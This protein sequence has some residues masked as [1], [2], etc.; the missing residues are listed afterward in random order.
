MPRVSQAPQGVTDG[1]SP[2]G[3][4]GFTDGCEMK[5]SPVR[6][7]LLMLVV[8]LAA[9][10]TWALIGSAATVSR[11]PTAILKIDTRRSGNDF[12]VGAVGLATDALELSGGRLS[13]SDDSLVRLMR[14]LGPA[15]L[16]VGGGNVD[17]S[18]WTSSNEAPPAWATSTITPADLSTLHSLLAVTGWRVLL[19]VDLGHFEPARVADEA[20]YAR[21]IL[22]GELLGIEIGNEPDGYGEK[23]GNRKFSLRPASYGVDEYVREAATYRRELRAATPGLAVYGPAA[24]GS[25]WL[26]R[27]GVAGSMFAVL[28]Q[29]YY[30]TSTCPNAPAAEPPP[31]AAGILSPAVRLRED[32]ALEV[33]AQ[34]G[35]ITGRSIRIDET[36]DI[37]YCSEGTPGSPS[38]ASALWALDWTLRAVSSGVKGVNF[39]GAFGKCADNAQSQTPICSTGR[40]AA[41]AGDVA[42]QPEYYG[43]LAARQLEGGRFVPASLTAPSQLPNITTWATVASN[44]TVRIAIDNMAIT[45]LA[46]PVSI[47]ISGY[48]GTEETLAAP[49]AE[50]GSGITLG[51]VVV[52]STEKWRP[53]T[54]RLFHSRH[55]ARI[56]IQPASAVVVTLRPKRLPR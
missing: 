9:A 28:T 50:A 45:G 5:G 46:Q 26:I 10:G 48:T 22:G 41:D 33:I 36:N 47:P 29:H 11:A 42:P 32:Q 24:G 7:V 51:G 4:L 12:A 38:M 44:G 23:T 52:T 3:R 16:R 40:E 25:G 8:V 19:G 43:L 15:V 49:S 55:L 2:T 53:R 30:P 34:A 35:A 39:H 13:A 27:M 37:S 17:F 54:I 56:I 18:W 21:K 31:T 14:L 20:R 1:S 6:R